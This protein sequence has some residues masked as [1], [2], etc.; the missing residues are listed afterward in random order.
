MDPSADPRNGYWVSRTVIDSAGR[1]I[2]LATVA[3][4]VVPVTT[5]EFAVFCDPAL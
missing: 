1:P 5:L 4:G 3:A 2:W